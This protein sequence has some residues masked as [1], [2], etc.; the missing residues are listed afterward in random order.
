[1]GPLPIYSEICLNGSVLAMRSGMMNAIGVLILPS[2]SS[3]FGNGFLST[4]FTVRS[5][6]GT[7]SCW[8]ALIKSPIWSRAAQRSRLAATSLASTGSPSW[9]LSPGRRRKVQVRP[10]EET[11]SASTICRC[12]CSSSS[13]P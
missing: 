11:S 13:T 8:I 10:S 7:S 2:A 1:M 4:H 12:G 6:T 3:I 9:N 5:S